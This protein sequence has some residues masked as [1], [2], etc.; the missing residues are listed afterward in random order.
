[1]NTF[2]KLYNLDVSLLSF[3]VLSVNERLFPCFKTELVLKTDCSPL[4]NNLARLNIHCNALDTASNLNKFIADT[5]YG[6]PYACQGQNLGP[7]GLLWE[8]DWR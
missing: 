7:N 1:M 5:Y 2:A 6:M 4:P 3:Y 8:Y